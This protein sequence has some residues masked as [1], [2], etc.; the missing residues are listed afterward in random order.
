MNSGNDVFLIFSAAFFRSFAVSCASVLIGIYLADLGFNLIEI[1]FVISAGLFGSA[2]ATLAAGVWGDRVG[3]KTVL[4]LTSLL[5]AA[6][7][8]FFVYATSFPV[9]LASAFLG[10]INGMGRDRGPQN[11]VDQAIIPQ[12]TNEKGRT[13]SFVG[14]H[15][16]LD[17]GHSLGAL[18]VG[19][20]YFIRM[21]TGIS[22]MESYQWMFIFYSA[23]LLLNAVLY[24]GLSKGIRIPHHE[25]K[26]VKIS[27]GSKTIIAKLAALFGLDSFAGGFL[28]SA[29]ISYWFYKKFGVGEEF[30]G[31]LFFL[32]RGL[33]VLS[34]IGSFWL[35]K[36]IGLV[37][38]MVFT[39]IPAS[40]LMMTAAISPNVWVAALLFLARESLSSM[41]I[42][43]RQSYIM[44][45]VGSR[46]RTFAAGVT[47][48]TR[49]L[50]TAVGPSVAGVFMQALN[51]TF[52]LF[53]GSIL[54]IC[55]DLLLFRSFRHIKPPEERI[56]K[57]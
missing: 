41:D 20:P 22:P 16:I 45:V 55:Y 48:V 47:N 33:N 35:S 57:S 49:N 19:I 28:T 43:A 31:P 2:L 5:M 7:G 38:T 32:A 15:V 11:A 29:F 24:S 6:G 30:L 27:A 1:G 3:R 50:G 14:Y 40:L 56:S 18:A 17:I 53:F 21:K 10:L 42:P 44:A 46:E 26:H 13:Q 51:L 4:I 23:L 34:Y 52:P 25:E 12:T 37:N 9:I 54:K 36:R 8:V 39:H